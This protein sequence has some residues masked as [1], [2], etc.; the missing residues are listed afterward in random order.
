MAAQKN[1]FRDYFFTLFSEVFGERI[2]T[3]LIL[4]YLSSGILRIGTIAAGIG[5]YLSFFGIDDI[6]LIE[7]LIIALFCGINLI[8]ITLSGITENLLTALKVIPLVVIALL[9]LPSVELQNLTP[10]V[11]ITAT[12]LVKTVLLVYWPF[13][14][15][16]ISTIPVDEMRDSRMVP[17]A[18]AIVM[19]VVSAEYLLLNIALI[20]SV[21]SA[22]LAA[23][24]APIATAAALILSRSGSTVAVIGIIAMLS[25]LNAYLV[26]GSRLLHST[27]VALHVSSLTSLNPRGAPMAPLLLIALLS[28]GILSPSNSFEALAVLSVL[29]ILVP[30]WCISCGSGIFKAL[31]HYCRNCQLGRITSP[32]ISF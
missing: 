19:L 4:L 28:A 7:L 12:G 13:T 9:L 3:I 26:G 16:E 22:V 21:G 17:Y 29:T 5:Q 24:P 20:G 31:D 32:F 14:G 25:A 1:R 18:L 8:G 6:L 11:P 30:Y 27:A 23:S 15:F 10:L 2:A